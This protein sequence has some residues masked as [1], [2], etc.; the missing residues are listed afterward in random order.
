ME[1]IMIKVGS[2]SG[3]GGMSLKVA[4]AEGD[5]LKEEG[6]GPSEAA[7]SRER[8]GRLARQTGKQWVGTMI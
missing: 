3:E 4:E 7:R 2:A 6:H 5:C 1:K 8:A